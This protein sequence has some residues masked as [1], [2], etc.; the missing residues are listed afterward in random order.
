MH[1]VT[2]KK[3]G[4][5]KCPKFGFASCY[6][7]EA[8]QPRWL[9]GAKHKENKLNQKKRKEK[10]RTNKKKLHVYGKMTKLN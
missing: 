8:F 10:K 5:E 1:L 6:L 9:L 2:K 4:R 7:A 3:K